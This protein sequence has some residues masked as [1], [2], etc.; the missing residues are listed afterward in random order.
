VTTFAEQIGLAFQAIDDVLDATSTSDAI[1]K[2]VGSD[3]EKNKT[4]FMNFFTPEQAI[5]CAEQYTN[6]AIEAISA[7]DNSERLINIAKFL[8]ERDK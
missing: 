5:A 6:S 4:T 3:K 1:G 7:Y 8:C 2:S